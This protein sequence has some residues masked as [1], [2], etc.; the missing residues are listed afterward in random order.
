MKFGL[1]PGGEVAGVSV[2]T[3]RQSV[4]LAASLPSSNAAIVSGYRP[5]SQIC[6]NV[7]IASYMEEGGAI[8]S[9]RNQVLNSFEPIP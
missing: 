8:W 1:T 4:R 5:D 6:I 2:G 3:G 9:T 7:D